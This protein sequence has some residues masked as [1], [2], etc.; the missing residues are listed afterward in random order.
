MPKMCDKITD[1]FADK[2]VDVIKEAAW[3]AEETL[4]FS[5]LGP[6]NQVG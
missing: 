6:C 2:A 3:S 5:D 1:M 4:Y